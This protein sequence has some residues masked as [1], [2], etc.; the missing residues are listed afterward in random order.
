ML[1]SSAITDLSID[2]EITWISWRQKKILWLPTECRGG[3]AAVRGSI[4]IIGCQSGRV[5]LI[6]FGI[7]ELDALSPVANLLAEE[8]KLKRQ[9]LV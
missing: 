1:G 9:R 3:E 7:K 5:L 6:R 4:I 8:P 2:E